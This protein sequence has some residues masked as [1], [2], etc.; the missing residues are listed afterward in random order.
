MED[1]KNKTLAIYLYT[2]SR[3]WKLEKHEKDV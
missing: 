2:N 1:F 3:I